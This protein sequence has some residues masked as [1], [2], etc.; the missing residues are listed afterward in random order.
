MQKPYLVALCDAPTVPADTRIRAE[1]AYATELEKRMGSADAVA[2]AMN[3]WKLGNEDE[4]DA[5]TPD[6][7]MIASR[8]RRASLDAQQA[9][10]RHL[11]EQPGAYFDVRLA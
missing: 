1:T 9:A 7:V 11:G 8:W 4:V 3:I 6:D 10:F 5:L 2:A